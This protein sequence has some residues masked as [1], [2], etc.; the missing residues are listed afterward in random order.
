MDAYN[1]PDEKAFQV[2]LR[3]FVNM[4]FK[5]DEPANGKGGWTDQGRNDMRYFP[6]G[7]RRFQG[8]PF[9]VIVPEEN[10]N[11]SCLTMRFMS[12]ELKA[13]VENEGIPVK[14][15]AKRLFIMHSSAWTPNDGRSV[16]DYTAHYADG[17]QETFGA[18]CVKH[19]RDWWTPT[20]PDSE[21]GHIAWIG[22]LA[23]EGWGAEVAMFMMAWN[24]PHP[25]K[26]IERITMVG[27]HPHYVL[28][29]ISGEKP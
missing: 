2:N 9:D 13:K 15:K 29:A 3:P 26:E 11:R 4:A 12:P 23:Y 21:D 7:P 6:V 28:V 19:L 18:H 16:G 10:D 17:T 25:D 24:N 1:V 8:V 22:K 27:R 5:D 20:K 14:Q